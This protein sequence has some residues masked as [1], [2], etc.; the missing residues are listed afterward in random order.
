VLSALADAG[1]YGG[2]WYR[3]A[4]FPGADDPAAYGYAPGDPSL[5]TSED[6]VARVVN[7]PTD[8]DLDT[9]RRIVDLV[10]RITGSTPDS[11]GS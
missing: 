3:P 8:V 6:L 4:L 11:A 10:R 9:A 7:L 1:F 5:A 2:R